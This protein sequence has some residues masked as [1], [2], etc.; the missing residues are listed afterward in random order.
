MYAAPSTASQLDDPRSAR[1]SCAGAQPAAVLHPN[2]AEILI[3][4]FFSYEGFISKT[5]AAYTLLPRIPRTYVV[6]PGP[7]GVKRVIDTAQWGI[8]SEVPGSRVRRLG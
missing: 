2:I 5:K 7:D 8:V 3:N 1:C 4:S 6:R